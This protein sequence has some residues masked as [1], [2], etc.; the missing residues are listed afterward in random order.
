MKISCFGS[1]MLSTIKGSNICLAETMVS[2]LTM[3]WIEK[4]SFLPSGESSFMIRKPSLFRFSYIYY[5]A[6]SRFLVCVSACVC[7][8]RQ[9][10]CVF[11][12]VSR[13]EPDVKLKK[14]K[15]KEKIEIFAIKN[16]PDLIGKKE[17][18]L[19]KLL[20][21]V[22]ITTPTTKKKLIQAKSKKLNIL[23]VLKQS[24]CGWLQ[25]LPKWNILDW[26]LP[27]NACSRLT[28]TTSFW[29]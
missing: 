22:H 12:L 10:L 2:I 27:P 20:Y 14:K 15:H 1:R 13:F 25:S 9:L 28:N 8:K 24:F 16:R 17:K 29:M 7:N 4:A 19:V 11:S 23:F 21:I 6:W 3:E 5:S 26:F 18:K